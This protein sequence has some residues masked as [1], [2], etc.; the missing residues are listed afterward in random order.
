MVRLTPVPLAG[1]F[2]IV[3]MAYLA[4]PK[5]A[6]Y[7][8]QIAAPANDCGDGPRIRAHVLTNGNVVLN[9]ASE[10][11]SPSALE[12]RLLKLYAP[13]VE[14]VSADADTPMQAVSDVI[15]IAK[16]HI[17]VVAI[18]TLSVSQQPC[19]LVW[20]PTRPEITSLVDVQKQ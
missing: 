9:T 17:H 10:Q 11:I 8:I 6:G 7:A 14:L 13:I 18:V 4:A 12:S 19:W 2:L 3:A 16:R 1:V 15:D 20:P 5:Q